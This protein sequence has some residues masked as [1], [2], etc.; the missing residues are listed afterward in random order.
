VNAELK[1]RGLTNPSDNEIDAA[2]YASAEQ[3]KAALLISRADRRRFGKLKDE[4]ANNYLLG[5]DQYPDTLEKAGRILANNQTTKIGAPY[6][7]DPM[8]RGWHSCS[9]GDE[10]AEAA[11]EAEQAAERRA[12]E[13]A[14]TK[15]RRLAATSAR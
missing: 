11:E 3:V 10:A 14:P 15:A 9:E 2:E 1:K 13:V 6:R 4:L 5:T 7:G 12:K 8:P